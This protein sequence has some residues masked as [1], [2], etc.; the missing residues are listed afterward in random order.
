MGDIDK[1]QAWATN[2]VV[3]AKPTTEAGGWLAVERITRPAM[4]ERDRVGRHAAN[5]LFGATAASPYPEKYARTDRLLTDEQLWLVYQRTPDVRACV[6]AIVRR[7]ATWDWIVEP[8]LPPNDPDWPEAKAE[9]DAAMAFLQAPNTDGETWQELMTKVCTDLM[10]FDSGV[11]ENVFEGDVR[12]EGVQPGE[13]LQELVALR[14]STVFP[15][16]DGY[17]HL[18]GYRQNATGL[19]GQWLVDDGSGDS[20]TVT[21][22]FAPEQ[23]TVLRLFPN[24]ATPL[25]CPLIETLV[26]E[27]IT[28]MRAS[29]HSMLAFDADEIPPGILVL[30]GIAGKAAQAAK[31][32]LQ[33][34]RG[35]DHKVRV[36]T[37][38][39]PKAT[40][41]HWVELRHTAKDV[42]FVNVIGQVRRTIWRV[43][44]VLPVEMGASEDIPRA[45][46][47]VQL[48]VSTSHLIG[49]ILE[50]VEAKINA[51]ILPLVVEDA[52][53]M[54][55]LRFRFDRESKL[56][57][58][59]QK[60]VAATLVQLVR[61]G[62]LTRNEARAIRGDA[63]VVGGDVVT[64]TT[65]Q[66]V[67]PLTMVVGPDGGTGSPTGG[68]TSPPEGPPDTPPEGPPPGEVD[69]PAARTIGEFPPATQEALRN[70]A[71][72]HNE[73]VGDDERKRTTADTL[74]QVYKR[75]IGA[76]KTNPESV[77]PNVTSAEQW[78]MARVNSFLYALQNLRYRSGKH[79]TDLLPEAHPMST[80]GDEDRAVG[81][82]DPTNFP[83]QG[84]D[85]KVSLRNSR[86]D[87]FDP[88][89]AEK[90][91]TDYPSIW[92]RGGNIKGDDQYRDLTPVVKRGGVVENRKE[93][94]AVRLREAWAARHFQDNR[95]AGV[96]AQ[97]KWYVV[98]TLGE[99]G[100]KDV[101]DEAKAR[102]DERDAVQA[103]RSPACRMDG[104]SEAE[105][106]S[107]K[108][109]EIMAEKPGTTREQATAIAY[110]LCEQSC[111]QRAIAARSQHDPTMPSAWQSPGPFRNVRTIDL[112]MLH[113]VVSDYT[114]A[115]SPLYRKAQDEVTAM[116][117]AAYRPGT[118]SDEEADRLIARANAVLD[119]L[120]REWAMATDSLYQ[121][122]GRVGVQAARQWS[123]VPT[124]Q[125]YREAATLYGERAM[126]YLR[127]PGGLVADLRV[128]VS[129][130]IQSLVAER[131]K[132]NP[133]ES[134]NGMVGVDVA[135]DAMQGAFEAEQYRIT[136]WSGRLV[137]VAN[138]AAARGLLEAG[139][140][141]ID[142]GPQPTE[143]FVEWVHV[144]DRAMCA[145]C[146]T[147][148]D[149]GFRP[150]SSLTTVP[151]GDTECRARCRCVLV[152][153]TR[154][155]IEGG[156]AVRIGPV[157]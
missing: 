9:A 4:D 146:T 119:K 101:I 11:I 153:W 114:R 82:T 128:R 17:G 75:G 134:L 125:D 54:A 60:D 69:P 72:E 126:A 5:T 94:A 154:A 8:T 127:E 70:K 16:V 33:Q 51:R 61:E 36:I 12:A 93:E 95:L 41:A 85:L 129:L 6:D 29:E 74:A 122:A 86:W 15:V 109:P 21:P 113:D 25:G 156:Q 108:I 80:D 55:R 13:D 26:N 106:V 145:T 102:V 112:T 133:P 77:R 100:M 118:L 103:E 136:N 83:K 2:A 45:V 3:L 49:P 68:P 23:I 88:A 52:N 152:M 91:R 78:A 31:A 66:G 71:R 96:V 65:G 107:R 46:G 38:P 57:P 10:I 117:R 14:G 131:G 19:N 141:V 151:G 98:G 148:G 121:R 111:E 120:E 115:V 24:T 64:L 124:G 99:R 39:D 130:T 79:D 37:N 59:E 139:T 123:G 50:L 137:E 40:G 43:F 1:M 81:D 28:V 92:K 18:L 20:S 149:Q 73:D 84:D 97:I 44:G 157:G 62:V 7:V 27:I 116:V 140:A 132:Y 104:E 22:T 47:Q 143:W 150:L 67:F 48:D 32:D 35:K 34:L 138:A 76:Y 90:L 110:S 135:A 147:E 142:G 87:V 89:Y 63:P 58:A 155:E 42:D 144:G 30:T 53:A 105:C 56:S